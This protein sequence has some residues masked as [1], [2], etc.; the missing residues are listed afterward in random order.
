MSTKFKHSGNLGDIIFSLPTIIALGG[1]ILYIGGG[2][3][4]L[5]RP[6]SSAMI[7]Q[8]IE[9]L[10]GQPYLADV[11]PYQNETVDYDLDKF[12]D[13]HGPGSDVHLAWRHLDSFGVKYDLSLPW[14]EGIEPLYVNDIIIQNGFR[15]RDIPLNWRVLKAYEDKCVFVGFKNEYRTF[16]RKTGLNIRFHQIKNI[17]EL[18]RVIKGSKLFIGNQSLGFALAE[19]L[20]HP[21][22]LEVSYQ[23]SNVMPQSYNGHILLTTKLINYYL[24]T[25]RTYSPKKRINLLTRKRHY[26][27]R[28][29]LK[30]LLYDRSHSFHFAWNRSPFL[31]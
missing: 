14:L 25:K 12:R 18:A 4:W 11:L 7:E 31:V 1:G 24:K 8:M 21:R 27:I 10:K 5:M 17:R 2:K 15:S 9:L 19:A 26:L 20:K 13:K 6:M 3:G 22:V 30:A 16:R 28:K 23:E 29:H